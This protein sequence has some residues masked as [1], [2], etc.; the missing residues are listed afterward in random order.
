MTGQLTVLFFASSTCREKLKSSVEVEKCCYWTD[1][2]H[3]S[4][5]GGKV[6][7]RIV[8]GRSILYAY[9][10]LLPM[11]PVFDTVLHVPLVRALPTLTQSSLRDY[12]LLQN[13]SNR[14]KYFYLV[15]PG[16]ACKSHRDILYQLS[17]RK[18]KDACDRND[19]ERAVLGIIAAT[20]TNKKHRPPL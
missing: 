12:V 13:M 10:T 7:A 9:L 11:H 16:G 2:K 3:I 19:L 4:S 18:I 17:G 20:R 1:R 5:W 14:L 6:R 8:Q 15:D